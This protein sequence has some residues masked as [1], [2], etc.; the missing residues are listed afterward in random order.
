MHSFDLQVFLALNVQA[1]IILSQV[2]KNDGVLRVAE[3]LKDYAARSRH[4][5]LV[6]RSRA[7]ILLG[8]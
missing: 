4:I 3:R 6:E 2:R 5:I 7:L 8:I 1:G